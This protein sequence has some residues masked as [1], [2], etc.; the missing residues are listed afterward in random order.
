MNALPA[1][2]RL[3]GLAIGLAVSALFVWLVL[4]KVSL[5]E[6]AEDA[7]TA[8]LAILSLSLVTKLF[9]V[10]FMT[11]RSRVLF[12]ALH[13]Y[14]LPALFRSI[15]VGLAGNALLPFRAG[16][17]LRVG[18]L[19]RVGGISAGACLGVLVLERLLDAFC[20]VLLFFT[21]APFTVLGDEARVSLYAFAGALTL[22]LALT[23]WVATHPEGT[24][25]LAAQLATPLP[26]ALTRRLL[27]PLEQLV[28]SLGTL[29]SPVA[30]AGVVGLSLGYWV[31]S[32]ASIQVW[33]WA[34]SLTLPWYAPFVVLF[35][36]ALGSFLPS[37]PGAVGTWHYFAVTALTLMGVATVQ[38]TS[39]AVVGHA[40]AFV[41]F[42]LMSLPILL[43]DLAR[44]W[45]Q[46]AGEAAA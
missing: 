13:A 43:P 21:V 40:M 29:S 33:F 18:Y 37:S 34:F 45:R 22:S 17:L 10:L 44:L 28:T 32:A 30:A 38:A 6:I 20:L 27:R 3:L 35:S 42:T 7:A 36:V 19:A 31:T 5:G 2:R 24:L 39:L 26:E 23:A 11:A 46:R 12:S 15:L 9:G 41:P 14:S 16:E 1:G 4:R 25:R 8:S